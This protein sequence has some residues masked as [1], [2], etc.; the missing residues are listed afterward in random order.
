MTKILNKRPI[1]FILYIWKAQQFIFQRDSKNNGCENKFGSENQIYGITR[2]A[3]MP[4]NKETSWHKSSQGLQ[5]NNCK[6]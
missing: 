1:R 3:F 6:I 5:L 2:L 4:E